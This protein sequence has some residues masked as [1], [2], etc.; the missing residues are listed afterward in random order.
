MFLTNL[1]ITNFRSYTHLEI[2]IPRRILLLSGGNA[3]GKTSFLEAIFYCATFASSLAENDRQLIRFAALREPLAV[4]RIIVQ[5]TKSE[6][7][8]RLEVRIIQEP[9]GNFSRIR[10]EI[11]LDGVKTTAQNAVGKF[12]AVLFIPQM[13]AILEGS[14]QERRRYLNITLSQSVPGYAQVLSEFK[15]I[16][17]QRNALLKLLSDR[18]TDPQQL[19]YWDDL[20]AKKAAVL[21]YHRIRALGSLEIYADD[22]HQ[23]LTSNQEKMRLIYQPSFDPAYALDDSRQ[24]SFS[25][26]A[27]VDRTGFSESDIAEGYLSRLKMIRKSEIERGISTTGPHR[28]E[29]RI[30]GNE[31]DLGNFGSRGQ[32][33]TA[34]ISLKLAEISWMK[35]Q[36][37]TSPL[38]L[39]DE[40]LAELDNQRR[41]DLMD[42]LDN[43]R[44]GILTTT[45]LSYFS[46]SF[47]KNHTVWHV[48]NGNIQKS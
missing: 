44:Q 20:M 24:E 41:K 31:I 2:E 46:D 42:W 13:T 38:L 43:C 28:D 39:L 4:A 34:L 29:F 17:T 47:I 8:H 30:L 23:H 18:R 12:P 48:A 11:L 7:D 35:A 40:T 9:C 33:W 25:L 36:T 45:D 14:P 16:V 26:T 5:F 21:I 3:Q 19:D 15:Q 22:A 32:I 37:G 10:K 27:S 6:S 1:S